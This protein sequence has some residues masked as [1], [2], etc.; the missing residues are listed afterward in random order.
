MGRDSLKTAAPAAMGVVR[1]EAAQKSPAVRPK[2]NA[3]PW[4]WHGQAVNESSENLTRTESAQC[5]GLK[6][7]PWRLNTK[8]D[9][10]FH[11]VIKMGDEDI[12]V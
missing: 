7:C 10:L 6:A 11:L 4:P 1:P 5:V 2:K 12:A 3:Y 8:F 9:G